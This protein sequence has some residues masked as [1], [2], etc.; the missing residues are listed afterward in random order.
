MRPRIL[1]VNDEEAIRYT[2][3]SLIRQERQDSGALTAYSGVGRYG[4]HGVDYRGKRHR[5]RAGGE[6]VR[7][8]I[9]KNI[10]GD[11]AGVFGV[12]WIGKQ[13]DNTL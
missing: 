5:Q 12:S 6:G 11:S 9:L 1:I 7:T 2:F 3:K 10:L 4:H 13:A 8:P